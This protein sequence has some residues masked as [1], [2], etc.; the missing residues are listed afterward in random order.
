MICCIPACSLTS[1]NSE[2]CVS[3]WQ[4]PVG[5]RAAGSDRGPETL[6]SEGALTACAELRSWGA[7]C[8]LDLMG[9]VALPAAHGTQPA[10]LLYPF[11]VRERG[12]LPAAQRMRDVCGPALHRLQGDTCWQW[13]PMLTVR[14]HLFCSIS[15]SACPCLS[16]QL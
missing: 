9:S 6:G 4:R 12:L 13:G 16:R 14:A 7:S 3:G 5:C 8:L 1:L 2:T 11:P 10:P 15:E